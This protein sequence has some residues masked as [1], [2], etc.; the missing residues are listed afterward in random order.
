[1]KQIGQL[2]GVS[3]STVSR[4]LSGAP[5]NVPVASETRERILKVVADFGY[6]PNPVARALRNARTGLIGLIVRDINDP[7][8]AVAIVTLTAHAQRHGYSVV[9]G[10]AASSAHAAASLSEALAM[11]HCEG[12]ILLGDLRDQ[13]RFQTHS[14]PLVGLWQGARAPDMPVL[15][16][17]NALGIQLSVSHLVALG[18]RRIGFL[19]GGVTGDG[20]ERRDA[21]LQAMAAADRVP[22]EGHVQVSVNDY[23]ATMHAAQTLLRR[24]DRPSAIVASTDV[25]AIGALKA[26]SLLGVRVPDEL[27]VVGFDDIPL[28]EFTV[29]SLTTVRQPMDQ[30]C[31][32]ALSELLELVSGAGESPPRLT[33]VA[34]TLV[35]RSSTAA[36]W[37]D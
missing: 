20:V 18:H 2:V 37:H 16:V 13:A 31:E 26:A 6:T 34:P 3:Q 29:P 5:T 33:N 9:L 15:N 12:A 27:S 8:F 35:V 10:H 30:L 28:A 25:A 14:I 1:M 23:A 19:Q 4:V 11:G 17:D 36:P 7:F 22:A 32:L 24:Q 21:F